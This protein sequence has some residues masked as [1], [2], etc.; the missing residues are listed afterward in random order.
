LQLNNIK[1]VPCIIL[2]KMEVFMVRKTTSTKRK[3][4]TS[5]STTRKYGKGSQAMVEKELQ[6]FKKGTAKSGKAGTP[7]KSRAQ[8]IAIGLSEAREKGIKVPKKRS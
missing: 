1:I 4:T 7:V 6:K 2:I 3:S 5:T 8:A